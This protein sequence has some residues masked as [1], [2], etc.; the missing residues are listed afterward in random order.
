[1]IGD[2]KG[3]AGIEGLV[4]PGFMLALLLVIYTSM[5][6]SLETSH[7][8]T[9]ATATQDGNYINITFLEGHYYNVEIIE[10][11]TDHGTAYSIDVPRY[12]GAP[13]T[14]A[15][16]IGRGWN[17]ENVRVTISDREAGTLETWHIGGE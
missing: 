15:H 10:D 7:G 16:E 3:I 13:I 17:L 14:N 4:L 11:G 9:T 12:G 8:F 2:N 1:M 6:P 5:P